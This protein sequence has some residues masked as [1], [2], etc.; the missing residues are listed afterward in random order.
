[1]FIVSFSSKVS[2]SPLSPEKVTNMESYISGIEQYQTIHT[3][4]GDTETKVP[5][6]TSTTCNGDNEF[7]SLSSKAIPTNQ[8]FSAKHDDE[9]LSSDNSSGQEPS[10]HKR[11]QFSESSDDKSLENLSNSHQNTLGLVETTPGHITVTYS[12]LAS[13]FKSVP[14]NY[15]LPSFESFLPPRFLAFPTFVV[16]STQLSVFPLSQESKLAVDKLLDYQDQ[17]AISTV[18]NPPDTIDSNK[19]YGYFCNGVFSRVETSHLSKTTATAYD[20]GELIHKLNTE[21]LFILPEDI[22]TIP[23]LRYRTAMFEL[24]CVNPKVGKAYLKELIWGQLLMV[25][26]VNVLTNQQGVH[27][28]LANFYSLDETM[29]YNDVVIKNGYS[30]KKSKIKSPP[31]PSTTN[32]SSLSGSVDT[33]D[34]NELAKQWGVSLP[35]LRIFQHAHKVPKWRPTGAEKT[36]TIFPTS[37][38]SP[39]CIWAQVFHNNTRNLKKLMEDMNA[40]YLNTTNASY[41]PS[42]G[43]V[44]AAKFSEDNLFYRAEILRVHSSGFIDVHF[45][46]YGNKECILYKDLRHI[47]TAF[48][49]LPRQAVLF[50]LANVFP[51]VASLGWSHEATA[52]LNELMLEKKTTVDVVSEEGSKLFV[53]AYSSSNPTV[54]FN[55]LL[56]QKGL[57]KAEIETATK[58]MRGFNSSKGPVKIGRGSAFN[59]QLSSNEHPTSPGHLTQTDQPFEQKWR[60][61]SPHDNRQT[62]KPFAKKRTVQPFNQ[63]ISDSQSQP[64]QKQSPKPFN[65]HKWTPH[66][67]SDNECNWFSNADSTSTVKIMQ[68]N[69][70]SK[71]LPVC[72]KVHSPTINHIDASVQALPDGRPSGS[73]TMPEKEVASV[74]LHINN[75]SSFYLTQVNENSLKELRRI[76]LDM[77]TRVPTSLEKIVNG[78]YCIAKYSGDGCYGRAQI[79]QVLPSKK[80]VTVRFL[81]YG[82]TDDISTS[83]IGELDPVHSHLPYQA[84]HCSL[85]GVVATSDSWTKGAIDYF[86]SIALNKLF[87]A[88]KIAEIDGIYSVKLTSDSIDVAQTLVTKGFAFYSYAANEVPPPLQNTTSFNECSTSPNVTAPLFNS[89]NIVTLPLDVTQVIL[90]QVISPDEIYLHV[91]SEERIAELEKLLTYVN[92]NDT[93]A[94]SWSLPVNSVCYAMFSE[95]SKWYRG[96]IVESSRDNYFVHFIDFGNYKTVSKSNVKLCPNEI[97]HLPV[98]AVQCSLNGIVPSKGSPTW[99]PACVE[100][101]NANYTSKVL[102]CKSLGSNFVELYDTSSN[103][104]NIAE[105]LIRCGYASRVER[106]NTSFTNIG[107]S[108]TKNFAVPSPSLSELFAEQVFLEVVVSDIESVSYFWIQN[109]SSDNIKALSALESNLQSYVTSQPGSFVPS[110]GDYCCAFFPEDNKWYRAKVLEININK[111]VVLYIDYGNTA[112]VNLHHILPITKELAALPP[113]AYCVSLTSECPSSLQTLVSLKQV[114]NNKI[115]FMKVIDQSVDPPQV[116]LYDTSSGEDV[117]IAKYLIDSVTEVPSPIAICSDTV[118]STTST[119]LVT[120]LSSDAHEPSIIVM[121][122]QLSSVVLPSVDEFQVLIVHIESIYE[123]YVQLISDNLLLLLELAE[124]LKQYCSSAPALSSPPIPSQICLAKCEGEYYRAQVIS[125]DASSC[126]VYFI[127]YGNTENV[128]CTDLKQITSDI[129]SVPKQAIKCALVGIARGNSHITEK[130]KMEFVNTD[131]VICRVYSRSPFIVDFYSTKTSPNISLRERLVQQK[132]L[133]PLQQTSHLMPQVDL[134]AIGT[135]TVIATDIKNPTYFW[136]Q[137]V[138]DQKSRAEFEQVTHQLQEYCDAAFQLREKP[139]LGQLIAA[140]FIE[141]NMWYRAR[142]IDISQS[143]PVVRF[144]DYGNTQSTSN[145][146]MR[147]I[148]DDLIAHPARSVLCSLHGFV[149]PASQSIE[150]TVE[151]FRE[152]IDKKPLQCV[153]KKA[154]DLDKSSVELCTL[155]GTDICQY[156]KENC[157]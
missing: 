101:I 36:L 69:P 11:S 61:W 95:D 53:N 92:I 73:L 7:N 111:A 43:E 91:A 100:F 62:N 58:T 55:N 44:C 107:F 18:T 109:V 113:F 150:K 137:V 48:L 132:I 123:I 83:E 31:S 104:D 93:C 10:F 157:K 66:N 156:M 6:A 152:L 8:F 146:N 99:D 77:Q 38:I 26:K 64:F 102:L 155:E 57:A 89:L 28:V 34:L 142:V 42:K 1:M 72:T 86:N 128:K 154:V 144:V 59:C 50:S 19:I 75:P 82:N 33:P 125:T 71:A 60:E 5:S 115:L 78:A 129:A 52:L 70:N 96:K 67:T 39:D 88:K 103:E 4:N 145:G 122:N 94:A 121:E 80:A 76:S 108:I 29:H 90:T 124:K 84:I 118:S 139:L 20:T 35:E 81:D 110:Q 133:P 54:L 116:E 98:Q 12:I 153:Y 138:I 114:T 45:I 134:A 74:V 17:V 16:S 87:M 13:A 3:S 51:L 24:E 135:T 97:L 9:D 21:S 140:R 25:H 23:P 151:M 56:V 130:V 119:S 22:L 15:V 117:N 41:V 32:S 47:R 63:K 105:V 126:L 27:V 112:S 131:A 40:V 136:V 143:L 79:I 147:A 68:S 149:Q 65:K 49:S 148:A 106:G 2:S 85:D 30:M 141:D 127:D 37:I 46:D 14:Q 120:T